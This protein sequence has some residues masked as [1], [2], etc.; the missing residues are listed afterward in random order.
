MAWNWGESIPIWKRTQPG[1][2]LHP[3]HMRRSRERTTCGAVR[4]AL[5][6]ASF[7]DSLNSANAPVTWT[8]LKV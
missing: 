6:Q 5:H 1:T 4:P 8:T 7:S 3:Q 2:R